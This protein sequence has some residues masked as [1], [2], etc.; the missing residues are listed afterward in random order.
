MGIGRRD[1]RLSTYV[2]T[3]ACYGHAASFD[4]AGCWAT[5]TRMLRVHARSPLT[6]VIRLVGC[7]SGVAFCTLP[8]LIPGGPEKYKSSDLTVTLL[9]P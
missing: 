3:V 6:N 4:I 8:V 9:C 1:A 2:S 5:N 7:V